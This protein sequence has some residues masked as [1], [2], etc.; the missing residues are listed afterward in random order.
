[1]SDNLKQ[2]PSLT[3][4]NIANACDGVYVGEADLQEKVICG[5]VIDSRLVDK[6]YLFIPI[7]GERVDGHIFIPQVFEKGAL[8]RSP[9]C[10][11][12]SP[13]NQHL[14]SQNHE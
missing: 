11:T 12:S 5:A 3:L 8:C 4:K 14:L 9:K 2:M 7:K 6:D 1:M 13:H 10:P